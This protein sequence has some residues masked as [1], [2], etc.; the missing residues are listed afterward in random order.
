MR[1]LALASL[2]ALAGCSL[3]MRSI[4]KPTAEVR[5]VAIT[6][7]GFTGVTGELALDVSNPNSFG[8]PLSGIDWQ[9]SIG[10]MR[11]VTGTVQLNETIPAKGVAPVKTTLTITATDAIEVAGV[12]AAGSRDYQVN[13]RLHFATKVGQVDV[14]V[15]HAGQLGSSARTTSFALP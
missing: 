7:A 9:L 5:T 3:F 2:T 12:L 1:L 6:S 15:A 13:V 8:V 14:D 11:A 10:G 4:E